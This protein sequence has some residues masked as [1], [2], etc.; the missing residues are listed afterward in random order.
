MF[1]LGAIVCL[2]ALLAISHTLLGY[3]L[4]FQSFRN[5]IPWII[6]VT[7]GLLTKPWEHR[8]K[9]WR[10]EVLI[11]AS[12]TG[13]ISLVQ[14]PYSYGT[15]FFYGAPLLVLTALYAVR[16]QPFAPHRLH[17]ALLACAILFAVFRLP[18]PDPRL[19]NGFYDPQ[20]PVASLKLE[21][22][23]LMVFEQEALA[24]QQLVPLVQQ[25][26][27][28][29]DFI[30]A[31]PDC[32]E[33]YFLSA[34]HNPTRAFYDCLSDPSLQDE[35]QLLT[36]LKKRRVNV[37][38]INHRPAFS[39]RLSAPLARAIEAEFPHRRSIFVSDYRTGDVVE[40]FTVLWSAGDVAT[41]SN[42]AAP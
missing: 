14:Y 13:L 42:I 2:V 38:V 21:R 37:V 29:G 33:A 11:L 25:L 4:W 34:R 22:C 10:Q 20:F 9:V 27:Q 41:P 24:Y 1:V 26:S 8:G 40:R 17:A 28:F 15:Y 35:Q 31:A 36:M 7:F 18:Q 3:F 5:L 30:Y 12:I 19:L 39:P 23:R 6:V 16:V 32:P